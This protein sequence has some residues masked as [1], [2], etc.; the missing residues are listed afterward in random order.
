M[1]KKK[2]KGYFYPFLRIA[3]SVLIVIASASG[4]Y[5]HYMEQMHMEETEQ[6]YTDTYTDPEIAREKA[7]DV[8]SKVSFSLSKGEHILLENFP[9][10][11]VKD[12][13]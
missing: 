1:T 6:T 4:I 11:S 10:D 9:T 7:K 13:E 5:T 3:A 12:L 8:L 2:K